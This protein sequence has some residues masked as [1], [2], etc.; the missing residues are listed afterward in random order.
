MRQQLASTPDATAAQQTKYFDR[1]NSYRNVG[2]DN[3]DPESRRRG[4][5]VLHFL[6]SLPIKQPDILEVGCGTGWLT[7]KIARY[8]KT[9][10]I[11]LSASAIEFAKQRGTNAEFVAGD[12]HKLDLPVRTFD[13]VV[14]VE[15]ISCV[16]AQARFLERVASLMKPG[17]FLILT[18]LNR[19]V[20]M[21]RS[22]TPLPRPPG[23]IA[24]WLTRRELHRLVKRDF[25]ILRSFTFL[26]A[27]DRGLLMRI[28]NSYKVN[29]SLNRVFSTDTITK[30]K[31]YLG[32]GHCR[33][34]LATRRGS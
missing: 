9:T 28:L 34:V 33:M 14:L 17:A 11:D 12:I 26:P 20:Y 27:G 7:E 16:P 32:L 5:L 19:F 18:S 3:I 21:R 15:V 30:V 13:V 8:G 1:W 31:E 24:N 25:R 2:F 29:W 10:A 6:D 4:E 23:E 22:D